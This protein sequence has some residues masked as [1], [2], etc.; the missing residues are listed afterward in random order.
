MGQYGNF[1]SF[2]LI[3]MTSAIQYKLFSKYK[4]LNKVLISVVLYTQ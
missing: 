2:L 4:L 1:I 3:G